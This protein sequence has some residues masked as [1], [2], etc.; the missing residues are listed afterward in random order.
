MVN[1]LFDESSFPDIYLAY[2]IP[3]SPSKMILK[4]K[5]AP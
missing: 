2:F 5:G 4:L 3:E 1:I